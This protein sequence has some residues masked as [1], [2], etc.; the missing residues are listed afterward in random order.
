MHKKFNDLSKFINV[1]KIEIK[2]DPKIKNLNPV[3]SKN[4][5]FKLDLSIKKQG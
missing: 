4:S 3:H 2:I 5:F 1:P